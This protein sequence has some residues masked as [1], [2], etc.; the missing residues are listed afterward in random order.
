MEH[1][2]SQKETEITVE[3]INRKTIE[4]LQKPSVCVEFSEELLYKASKIQFSAYHYNFDSG[5]QGIYELL[6]DEFC[7][8]SAALIFYWLNQ[9]LYYVNNP[10]S[11][12][13]MHDDGRKLKAYLEE[14]I[15]KGHFKEILQFVPL[16]FITGPMRMTDELHAK[17]KHLNEIPLDVFLPVGMGFDTTATCKEINKYLNLSRIKTLYCFDLVNTSDVKKIKA[18]KGLTHLNLC[19]NGYI[20]TKPK[21]AT[22]S[23]LLHLENLESLRMDFYVRF[24]ALEKLSEFKNLSH[25]KINVEKEDYSFLNALS[26]L[27]S[28]DFTS[29]TSVDLSKIADMIQLETLVISGCPNLIDVKGLG[30]LT[31][32]KYL[33]IEFTKKLKKPEGVFNLNLQTLIF[34]G[35]VMSASAFKG[36]EKTNIEVLQIDCKALKQVDFLPKKSL[37]Q[38]NLYNFENNIELLQKI[39]KMDLGEC[40]IIK[41]DWKNAL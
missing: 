9:P 8:K 10:D 2:N 28:L 19:F 18:E 14:R 35:V 36:L 24:K 15:L 32:L 12:H 41:R 11:N 20:S 21:Y 6:E 22:I 13:S 26:N 33:K 40:E 27:K 38:L 29:S 5:Y 34:K 37:K 3:E 39:E 23:D 17:Q 25:L 1:L 4:I 31:R 7:D 16:D 30:K